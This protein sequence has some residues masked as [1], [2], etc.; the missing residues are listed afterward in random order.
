MGDPAGPQPPDEPG[1]HTHR[2]HP[3]PDP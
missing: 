2:R 1:R 3:V